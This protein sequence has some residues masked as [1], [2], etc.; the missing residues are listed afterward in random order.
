MEVTVKNQSLRHVNFLALSEV[1]P[2]GWEIINNRMNALSF[3]LEQQSNFTDV[4][5]DRVVQYFDLKNGESRR[6]TT[7]L[8]ATY[9]GKFLLPA[10]H[11]EAMYDHSTNAATA[12][13]WTIIRKSE[14]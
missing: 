8:I 4:R 12:G 7:T 6:F 2:A 10:V 11:C 1:I 14:Q 5:D 3:E 9:A 13:G